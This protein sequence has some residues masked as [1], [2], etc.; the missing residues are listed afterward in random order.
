[1]NTKVKGFIAK[2]A[3]HRKNI[4]VGGYVS[5]DEFI[6][7]FNLKEKSDELFIIKGKQNL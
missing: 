7:K 5:D 3:Q 1:M 4:L 2:T 6:I